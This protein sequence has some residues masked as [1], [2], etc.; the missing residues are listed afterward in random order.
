MDKQELRVKLRAMR[1]AFSPSMQE[2]ACLAVYR[3]LQD[4]SPY[5][6]AQC[7]MVYMACR[8]ELSLVPVIDELLAGEKE[9]LL[10]RCEAPGVMTARRITDRSQL[11]S[12][13]FGLMEPDVACRIIPP[14]K[15]DLILVP[16]VAFDRKGHRLGQGGGYYDRFLA[17]THALRVGVCHDETL[18]ADVPCEA[19]DHMMD[20]VIT[21]RETIWLDRHRRNGH[22]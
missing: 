21:P 13:A 5:R 17:K 6:D 22:G 9:L 3:R 18:I 11:V 1:R 16:G 14:N 4:F 20:A 10:P 2:T 8:G 15:I 7:I 12:G 19:H